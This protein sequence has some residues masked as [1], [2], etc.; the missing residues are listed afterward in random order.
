[1]TYATYDEARRAAGAAS[2]ANHCGY[3]VWLVGPSRYAIGLYQGGDEKREG[4]CRK[5]CGIPTSKAK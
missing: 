5:V 1:M 3:T 4:F 2:N